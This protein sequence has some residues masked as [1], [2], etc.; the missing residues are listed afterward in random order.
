MSQSTMQLL[1]ILDAGA[2][3]GKLIDRSVR[4]N[5][6]ESDLLPMNTPA[7]ELAKK[8][9]ALIISGGPERYAIETTH[10]SL[11]C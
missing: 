2:Q 3:Y 4:E 10:T 5:G 1:G 11:L 6:V 9:R 8:Y 7:E